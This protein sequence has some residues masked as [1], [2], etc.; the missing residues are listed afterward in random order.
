MCARLASHVAL[1]LSELIGPDW[2]GFSLSV[3]GLQHPYWRRP[4][5]AGELRA[6][7][8]RTQ[9][10][11]ILEHQLSRLRADFDRLSQDADEAEA[12]ADYYR[13]QLRLESRF[14]LMLSAFSTTRES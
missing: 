2:D 13:R 3:D 9:Q 8:Y 7:F 12:R 6:M 4:F 1:D 11:T 10:V 5:T 14:S